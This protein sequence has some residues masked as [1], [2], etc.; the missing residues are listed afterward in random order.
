MLAY[1]TE[2]QAYISSKCRDVVLPI[3]D[4]M[5]DDDAIIECTRCGIQF[6]THRQ[7]SNA[8]AAAVTK[9]WNDILAWSARVCGL[10]FK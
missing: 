9:L 2:P 8:Y 7:I 3:S 6:G 4:D 1:Q 10:H 5:P